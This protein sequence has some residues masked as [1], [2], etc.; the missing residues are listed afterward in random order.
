MEGRA[1]SFLFCFFNSPYPHEG[2]LNK[3]YITKVK[4]RIIVI[5]VTTMKNRKFMYRCTEKLT[6]VIIQFTINVLYSKWE[7]KVWQLFSSDMIPSTKTT[8]WTEIDPWLT[9]LLYLH[10][11]FKEL[12][13]ERSGESINGL[14]PTV[15]I[16]QIMWALKMKPLKR[17][18]WETCFDRR[19]I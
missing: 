14:Y 19:N 12:F 3:S 5:C 4:E 7:R 13:D 16:R 10:T 17:E 9:D 15:T 18:R 2:T 1:L 11:R 8:R 6:N